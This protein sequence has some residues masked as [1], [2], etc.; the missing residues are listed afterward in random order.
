[1]PGILRTGS[2]AKNFASFPGATHTSPRGFA[3]SLAIFAT[4]R[5]EASPPEHGREVVAV[6][7]RN[8]LSAAAN[9][10]PC[11][12]SV[13]ERSRYASSIDAIST[14]GEYFERIVA[15]RS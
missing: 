6:I 4:R 1:M 11:I 2:G 8:N 7:S 13:P 10:G 5:V 15:T 3:C 12:R 14:I 9:D